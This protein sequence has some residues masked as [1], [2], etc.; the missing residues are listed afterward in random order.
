MEPSADTDIHLDQDSFPNLFAEPVENLIIL[1]AF[2][3][4]TH[5]AEEDR[6]VSFCFDYLR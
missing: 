1:L 2:P 3:Q 5:P 4:H 6:N